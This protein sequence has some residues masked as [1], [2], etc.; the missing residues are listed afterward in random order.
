[1]QTLTTRA[2]FVALSAALLLAACSTPM[3]MEASTPPAPAPARPPVAA[4]TTPPAPV[5]MTPAIP[6]G[7]RQDF[8]QNVGDR[9]LFAYDRIDIGDGSR[10]TL[11]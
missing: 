5:A 10:Q 11:P 1:M 4:P 8:S 9:V 7:S 2:R 3:K 6:P